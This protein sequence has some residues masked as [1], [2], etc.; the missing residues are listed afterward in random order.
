MQLK[1]TRAKS[2]KGTFKKEWLFSLE[3]LLHV[4][5]DERASLERYNL[6]ND[7][8][9]PMSDLVADNENGAY[10][11]IRTTRFSD[12]LTGTRY[13]SVTLKE[14]VQAQEAITTACLQIQNYFSIA[15]SFDGNVRVLELS[16]S[17]AEIV[18]TA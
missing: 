17:G 3:A 12:L 2:E 6:I 15:D 4:T 14:L 16:G 13:T 7:L 5:A 10:L 11:K 18:A 9:W 8:V 1:F